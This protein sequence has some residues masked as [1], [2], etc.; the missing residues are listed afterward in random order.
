MR[1][2]PCPCGFGAFLSV[3]GKQNRSSIYFE[4]VFEP[5]RNPKKVDSKP[6]RGERVYKRAAEAQRDLFRKRKSKETDEWLI[7]CRRQKN[8][9]EQSELC[10][11]VSSGSKKDAM[12]FGLLDL[13]LH[14]FICIST[15]WI[16]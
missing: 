8:K 13:N 15:S 10:S 5:S 9:P 2:P 3:K 12:R 11:D 4:K 16:S 1:Q 7:F 14:S 6:E